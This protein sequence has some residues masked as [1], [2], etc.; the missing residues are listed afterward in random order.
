M[1]D[2]LT[3]RERLAKIVAEE[4][5]DGRRIVRFLVQVADGELHSE[6]FKPCHRMDSAKELVKIGLT[7]FEDYIHANSTTPRSRAKRTSLPDADLSP[8]IAEAREQLAEYARELTQDGRTVI[9]MYAEVMEGIRNDEGFKPHHRIAAARE[10]IKRGFDEAYTRSAPE[11]RPAE[12]PELVTDDCE[13][14]TDD[15]ELTEEYLE[16][17]ENMAWIIEK[18]KR[19]AEQ[20]TPEEREEHEAAWRNKD[21]SMWEIIAAQPPPVITKEHARIGAAAFREAI[22]RWRQWDESNV[23]IPDP[24]KGLTQYNSL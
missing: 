5:G 14:N 24:P 12:D 15:S 13:L 16:S 9:R 21:L 22:E 2:N 7:E 4:T 1:Y 18:I 6:G 3:P 8:E 11:V 19:I 23:K 10:L 20:V 17:E